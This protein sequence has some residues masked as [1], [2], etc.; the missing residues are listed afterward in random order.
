MGEE[1]V[2]MQFSCDS[3]SFQ[4]GISVVQ[5]IAQSK[6]ANPII[7]NVLIN[8]EENQVLF[9]GTNLA[10]TVRCCIDAEVEQ[11]GQIAV[12]SRFIG[13]LARELEKGKVEVSL[14]SN[15]LQILSGKGEYRVGAIPA[16]EFPEFLPVTDGTELEFPS[17]EIRDI[18]RKTIFCTSSEKGRFEL[19]GVKVDIKDNEINFVS[20]DGRRMSLVKKQRE[21][22]VESPVSALIPTRVWQELARTLPESQ[23]VK[24]TLT[25][26][27]VMFEAGDITLVSSLLGDNF[28]PY[29]L[30]IP[31]EF[32]RSILIPRDTF[33]HALR[34]A[35]VVASE[36]T[37]QVILEIEGNEMIVR[38]ESQEV[39]DAKDVIEVQNDGEPVTLSYKGDFVI[40]F[41]KSVSTE[42]IGIHINEP[43]SPAGGKQEDSDEYLHILMPMKIHEKIETVSEEPV[44]EIE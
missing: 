41:L 28:P 16:D 31:K 11:K 8:A 43:G 13:N 20:S 19:D 22:P 7:E 34:R 26:N 35:C 39:G 3:S 5:S 25:S 32:T 36:S 38:G 27:R 4:R 15:R 6:I 10:Q 2:K 12:Q 29:D 42:R 18:I 30:L 14:M 40:D 37:N 44:E 1:R 17:E 9:T 33:E 24:M 21:E 23:S